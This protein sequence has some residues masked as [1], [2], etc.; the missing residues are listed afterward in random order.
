MFLLNLRVIFNFIIF[1]SFPIVMVAAIGLITTKIFLVVAITIL[2]IL[3]IF[4]I[5]VL[6]YITAV[7]E[8]L[9]TSIWY[10]A[11]KEWKTKLEYE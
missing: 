6:W 2:S 4:F 8:V 1:L 5:L 11:Y 3:F 10:F 9:K 7:L